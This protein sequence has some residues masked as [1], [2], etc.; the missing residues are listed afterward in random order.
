[1]LKFNVGKQGV[2]MLTKLIWLRLV[3]VMGP[4]EHANELRV[5]RKAG[6]FSSTATLAFQHRLCRLIWARRC[7]VHINFFWLSVHKK[8]LQKN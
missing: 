1:M 5:P 8:Q 4:C 3:S 6:F 7:R 2:R